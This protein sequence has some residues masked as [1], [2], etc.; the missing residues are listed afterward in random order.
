MRRPAVTWILDSV[1]LF[2]MASALVWPLYKVKFT[3]KWASIESTFISDARFLRDHWPNPRWQP[4]WYTGTRFDYVYPPALRYGT[5][6]LMKLYPK[7]IPPRAY[8]IYVAFLYCLGIA[9]VYLLAR[10]GGGSRLAA[11]LGAIAVATISPS[12]LFLPEM[13]NDAAHYE[14]ARLGVLVRYGEG[15]H[16]SALAMLGFAL[17]FSMR[18]LKAGSAG[19]I[20][21]AAAACALV[22]SHNFYGATA[23]VMSFPVLAWSLWV[24]HEEPRML[25]RAGAITVFSYGLTALWLVPTYLIVTI[26]NMRFVSDRGNRWSLWATVVLAIVYMKLT[27]RYARGRPERAYSILLIG[28]TWVFLLNVLGNHHFQYRVIGEPMRLV[29]ELD[30]I[31]ILVGAE[32]LRRLW[33]KQQV[34][35]PKW[36]SG[37][38]W[39]RRG[40]AAVFIAAA[41]Y[42]GLKYAKRSW[43]PYV[44]DFGVAERLEYQIT[45]W[46]AK[47]M[48][49]ARAY[50]TGTVRFWYNAWYDLAQL[51][52]GSEQGLLNPVVQPA[53]WHLGMSEDVDHNIYWMQCTGVD[54]AIVHD[55]KSQEPYKDVMHPRKYEGRLE[56]VYDD[57]Q[58]NRIYQVP[59]RYRSLARVVDKTRLEALPLLPEDAPKDQLAKLAEI[60]E[61]GP[62]AP[63]ET[64]WEGTDQLRIRGR[65]GEGQT[66]FVQVTYNSP[67][68]AYAAGRRVPVRKTQLNFL[69]IDAPP[70]VEE[71][72]LR[73]ELPL[74][75]LLGR[76]V[77]G[78]SL[79]ALVLWVWKRGR[80]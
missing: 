61:K 52:G 42:P 9:G 13:R 37:R 12:F 21:A 36:F 70:G 67:W 60:L 22:V 1:L 34:Q 11:V 30:L 69:R 48:P 55:E 29:P 43:R 64:V 35:R 58:G 17:A 65:V 33:T 59:R 3:D 53:T 5:A 16:M 4:L 74:E 40:L 38:L 57:Q 68:K 26:N 49:N 51:G 77:Y 20:A 80:I 63:T 23:L 25:L 28:L 7:L 41:L 14:P 76:F 45:S 47:N 39:L 62:D 27:E 66:V 71:I 6:G 75:N 46:L 24:T 10:M 54:V 31:L 44:P 73:F 32:L 72:V 78:A 18:A 56:P 8:H 2:A 50:T 15:P 19:W 79:L